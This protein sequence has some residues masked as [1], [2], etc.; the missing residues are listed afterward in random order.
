MLAA[1]SHRSRGQTIVFVVSRLRSSLW[2]LAIAVSISCEAAGT[3]NGKA[4]FSGFVSNGRVKAKAA[5]TA[6]TQAASHTLSF[7]R[8]GRPGI[9]CGRG[10]PPHKRP[11]A[12]GCTAAFERQDW[13]PHCHQ[14]SS[15]QTILLILQV[16]LHSVIDA[17]NFGRG[18]L[19]SSPIPGRQS[20]TAESHA[21]SPPS[22]HFPT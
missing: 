20:L 7:A 22:A 2:A 14:D 21:P 11:K 5:E 8:Q 13:R 3:C 15:R 4:R 6:A 19:I 16:P 9:A 1:A 17:P 10:R 12:R 18:K